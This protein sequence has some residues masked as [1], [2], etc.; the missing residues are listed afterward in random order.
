MNL[1]T[2]PSILIN[3]HHLSTFNVPVS[4]YK[5]TEIVESQQITLSDWILASLKI[6]CPSNS[7][8][9]LLDK[10]RASESAAEKKHLKCHLP[11]ITPACHIRTRAK[12]IPFKD[13]LIH[14]SGFMQF[15]VDASPNANLTTDQLKERIIQ[16]PYIAFCALSASAKGVW[17]LVKIQNP[18]QLE[19]HF[20]YMEKDFNNLGITLDSKGK[21]P[22]D[23][24]FFS[25][26]ENAFVNPKAQTLYNKI[27][28]PKKRPIKN[29][30][31]ANTL[32]ESTS[33]DRL[34]H[35]ITERLIKLSLSKFSRGGKEG[36]HNGRLK[37]GYLAGGYIAAGILDEH[38]ITYQLI[39]NYESQFPEDSQSVRS[40]EIKALT[41][42]IEAGKSSPIQFQTIKR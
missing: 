27:I 36:Y 42:S 37:A 40:S 32:S 26:D 34:K 38:E 33:S 23:L 11:M 6:K 25:T 22:K 41:D 35:K 3:P 31:L 14:Y 13:T 5:S 39:Y 7:I 30:V 28:P 16:L 17:G 20:L 15:D 24:R 21:N 12:N 10:I 4:L 1:H 18:E 8:L 29:F 2:H 9:S 19:A